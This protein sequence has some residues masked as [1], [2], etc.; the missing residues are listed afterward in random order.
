MHG[1]ALM[2]LADT[3]LMMA[4][5]S[6]RPPCSHCVTVHA[7]VEY[8]RPV[9]QGVVTAWARVTYRD[10]RKISGVSSVFDESQEQLLT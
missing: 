8:F 9:T 7:A 10:G 4:I 1:G 6:I 2:S 5:K 3:A